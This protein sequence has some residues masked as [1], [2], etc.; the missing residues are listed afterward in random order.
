LG[1]LERKL[2]RTVKRRIKEMPLWTSQARTHENAL[3]RKLKRYLEQRIPRLVLVDRRI[4]CV[5]FAEEEYRPE[6]FFQ[7][8]GDYPLLAFE[9]KKMTR[10]S[11]KKNFKEALSQA[12]LYSSLYK[13]V[14]LVLYD[15]SRKRIYSRAF[16][17]GNQHESGF[18]R[19]LRDTHNIEIVSVSAEQ[20]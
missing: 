9:C 1:A 6:Y 13:Q 18:A 10:H 11:H 12:L 16:G 17:R 5:E 3:N 2:C 20:L 19:L 7:G 14:F 15:F 4:R 8:S